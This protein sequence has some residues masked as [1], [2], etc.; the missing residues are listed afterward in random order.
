MIA[1]LTLAML[2]RPATYCLLFWIDT[3]PE[4][5]SLAVAVCVG[6]HSELSSRSMKDS[7]TPPECLTKRRQKSTMWTLSDGMKDFSDGVHVMY[8]E[9][10]LEQLAYVQST[11]CLFFM[12]FLVNS[13]FIYKNVRQSLDSRFFSEIRSFFCSGPFNLSSFR[14]LAFPS[15]RRVSHFRTKR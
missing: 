9:S 13:I 5:V 15:W 10:E 11:C 12:D 8:M 1:C 2:F 7:R 3:F 4:R 14:S 6:S